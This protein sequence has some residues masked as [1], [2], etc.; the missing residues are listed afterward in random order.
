MEESSVLT[1][2]DDDFS[3]DQTPDMFTE[4][5][6]VTAKFSVYS[7]DAPTVVASVTSSAVSGIEDEGD[8]TPDMFTETSSVTAKFSVYSTD[9]PTIVASVTSS[10]VSG[11]EDEDSSPF[12]L[13][14]A[15]SKQPPVSESVSSSTGVTERPAEAPLST[16]APATEG[17]SS[18]D[19]ATEI[20]TSRTSVME[21][22]TFGEATGETETFVSVT[23]TSEEQGFSQEGEIIPDT[24]SPITSEATEPTAS[25][26]GKD[27]DTVAENI[28]QSSYMTITTG[29]SVSDHTTVDFTTVSSSSEH[30][31]DGFTMSTPIPSIIYHSI[32]DQQV[33]IITPSGSQAKT[34]L[35]EQTPTMVLHVSKP[36]TSTTIIFTEDAKDEDKL[37]STITDSI[38]EG[39]PTPGHLTKDNIIIDADTISI[40]PSSSFY[41]TIQTEEAGGITAVTM[42]Q[43]LEVK[44]EPEGSGTDSTTFFSPTPVT[45]F[46]ISATESSIPST[47]SEYLL[48]TSKPLTVE[49][50]SSMETSSEDTVTSAPQVISATTVSTKS[51]SEETYDLTTPHIVI[52][53]E[54]HTKP[55]LTLMKDDLL[56]K[57]T[58]DNVTES[59]T[60]IAI[61][62]TSH[63]QTL[64]ETTSTSSVTPV[65]SEEYTVSG[66]EKSMTSLPTTITAKSDNSTDE[67]LSSTIS[68]QTIAPSVDATPYTPLSTAPST[69]KPTTKASDDKSSGDGDSDEG[70]AVETSATTSVPSEDGWTVSH[71]TGSLFSTE[72]PTTMEHMDEKI[73]QDHNQSMFTEGIITTTKTDQP[74]HISPTS[75]GTAGVDGSGDDIMDTTTVK[76]DTKTQ[77][78]E[79]QTSEKEKLETV[80]PHTDGATSTPAHQETTKDHIDS[81]STEESIS[82]STVSSLHSTSKPD[83]M[84]QFVTTFVPESDT[85]S[86]E[87]SFEQA[88]SEITFTH[89][90]HSDISSEKTVL[91]TTSPMLPMAEAAIVQTKLPP[92]DDS[93]YDKT[94]PYPDNETPNPDIVQSVPLHPLDSVSTTES[95]SEEKATT[96]PLVAAA[97]T[98]STSAPASVGASSSFSSESGSNSSSSEESMS[99]ASTITLDGDVSEKITSES[100]SV[101]ST[102]AESGSVNSEIV[103]G[104]SEN[105][106]GE[107][108]TT[109]KPKID[110]MVQSLSTDEIETVFKVDPTTA[111]KME[112]T[113]VYS[114]SGTMTHSEFTTMVQAQSQ[115]VLIGSPET[116]LSFFSEEDDKLDS[117]ITTAPLLTE[118]EPPLRWEEITILPETGLDLGHTVIGETVEIPDIDECQS[119]PCRNG[120]TETCDYGW[121]K[122]QGHCYK[123]FPHRRNWDTAERECRMQ[124]AHLTSILSHEEQQFV[125]R[126][127]QDYQWIGLNDKMFDSDFRWTD[128]RPMQYENWRPNQPDSFFSSGEDCVV[129]IWHEDGQWNDVPCNYH[130]TFTCKK[131]TVAC[132]QPPLVENAHTFGKKRERYEINSLVRYQCRTGFIQRHIPTIRCRGDGRWDVPKIS[133]MNLGMKMFIAE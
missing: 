4:T 47:S 40:V 125:N 72:K 25:T 58:A 22:V 96:L 120:D 81:I 82:T 39:G 100:P 6:S 80:S 84:V 99:T 121:H 130:L 107:M 35:T 73:T 91:A 55:I 62:L 13:D 67:A 64:T 123:Y 3:G 87:F 103:S 108:M 50:I 94:D 51:R 65:S 2:S 5:S 79:T 34:D 54:T 119:N 69:V 85:P 28:M 33:V 7:T 12:N 44:E 98:F 128:G 17:E 83:V 92:P 114:T 126:L 112:S 45:L 18:G 124:G 11:I 109:N 31:Q 19:K 49:G 41:P 52:S 118:G 74:E 27:D 37:F 95:P 16:T 32:T 43:E 122:F 15:L 66:K 29:P 48:S 23:P 113:R 68:S 24:E 14:Y 115:P 61:S 93:D 75:P 59:V 60:E 1:T 133:C 106:S 97:I 57:D 71:K 26:T 21:S 10:A 110:S 36:S 104:S 42:T 131:G 90:P 63:S 78:D 89:H 132:S 129:M 9:A 88:R 127:G 30:K 116:T 105:V 111:S 101:V 117:D 56:G 46:K 70:S 8:Q 102:E 77:D 38:S 86:P 20:F 53:S 76:S